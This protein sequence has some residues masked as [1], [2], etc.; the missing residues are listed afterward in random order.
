MFKYISAFDFTNDKMNWK[1][2]ARSECWTKSSFS[3]IFT[4]EEVLWNHLS[5]SMLQNSGQI[6][7]YPILLSRP[8]HKISI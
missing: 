7:S 8:F 3:T 5:N 4:R 6:S 1:A 2:S